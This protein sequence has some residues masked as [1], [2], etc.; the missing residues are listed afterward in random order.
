ML[1]VRAP[2]AFYTFALLIPAVFWLNLYCI[3]VLVSNRTLADCLLKL[4]K[5]DTL[6]LLRCGTVEEAR[7]QAERARTRA[8]QGFL[9]FMEK[10]A[11]YRH[12]AV[13]AFLASLPLL[14][15]ALAAKQFESLPIEVA[16]PTAALLAAGCLRLSRLVLYFVRRQ[17]VE[18][19]ETV[20]GSRVA[21]ADRASKQVPVL[22][23][24]AADADESA[25]EKPAP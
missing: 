5:S 9:R 8:Q 21:Q 14:L 23:P 6:A 25:T 18:Y 24:V 3:L 19:R 1:Q 10:T 2:W 22:A 12:T 17:D 20:C 11:V 15:I 4:P 16:A 7:Q 13:Q